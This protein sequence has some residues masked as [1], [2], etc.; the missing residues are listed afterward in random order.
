MVKGIEHLAIFSS[1]TARL[2]D[3]YI[4]MFDFVQ[5]YDNGKGT[6]FLKAQDGAMIEFVTAE[7]DGTDHGA[8]VSGI[9]HIAIAVNDFEGMLEKLQKENVDVVTEPTES[10]GIKT[11]FF[12]DIDGNILHLI[13]R[14]NPL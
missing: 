2:K 12:R 5:V 11:F 6:Y 8:K 7:S 4:S 9:R 14:P 1:N 10:K 3:W 13:Y